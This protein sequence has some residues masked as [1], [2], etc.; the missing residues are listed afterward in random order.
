MADSPVHFFAPSF[1][2]PFYFPPL[3]SGDGGG[4]GAGAS[5]YRD[6]DAFAAILQA[7]RD[8]G[9]FADVSFGTA[10]D[11]R[12][13]GVDLV[14]AAVVNPDSWSEAEDG[15]PV[16]VVRRVAFTV[17]IV[18]RDEDP[19]ERYD[20]LDRLGCVAQNALDGVDLGGG[21]LAALSKTLWGRYEPAVNH[22][23]QWVVLHGEFTYLVPGL[24]AR[25]T[26]R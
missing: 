14:P 21:S 22:P 10:P 15:D 11:R 23:E 12:A 6:R 17:T 3:A 7:L 5:R 20:T 19:L 1:F 9:E 25:N 4:S 2:T 13:A 24:D 18:A 8:T 16:V 26:S